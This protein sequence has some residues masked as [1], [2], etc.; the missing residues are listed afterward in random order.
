MFAQAAK[1][2]VTNCRAMRRAVSRSGNVL[3]AS[4]TSSAISGKLEGGGA[5]NPASAENDIAIVNHRRLSG[6]DGFLRLVQLDAS[7]AVL[8]RGDGRAR[9]G[10]A[11]AN[12]HRDFK[13]LRRI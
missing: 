2:S 8:H 7:A 11:V 6:C 12:L 4:R 3:K 9:A 1:F 5:A 13:R 10:M